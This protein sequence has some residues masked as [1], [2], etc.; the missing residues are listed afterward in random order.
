MAKNWTGLAP[1]AL[2]IGAGVWA[3][4][5]P[6]LVRS[7]LEDALEFASET[8]EPLADRFERDVLPRARKTLRET[9][10]A[11]APLLETAADYASDWLE[12]G[13][14]AAGRAI[15]W[16]EEAVQDFAERTPKVVKKT[17]DWLGREI[18]KRDIPQK[19]SDFM[20][21]KWAKELAVRLDRQEKALHG[22]N[23][24]LEHVSRP[25]GGGISLGW[26]LLGAGAF[27][28]YRNPDVAHKALDAIKDYIPGSTSDHLERAG[29][30]VKD[31][32]D[33]VARGANPMDAAK[34]AASEAGSEIGKAAKGVKA[35]AEDA[36]HDAKRG[37][38]KMGEQI[39]DA[40][41]DVA[42]TAKDTAK[43]VARDAPKAN[44]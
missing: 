23:R 26:L 33:R 16:G 35:Q 20:D 18:V 36:V 38:Q 31:G 13:Q 28:L 43:D 15:D 39:G 44:A 41:K 21:T 8:V 6:E 11:A 10:K 3:A 1:L 17:R 2:L 27:Y 40:A 22:M 9:S 42:A 12:R 32:V 24:K 19:V 37:A 4:R 34:D 30:A 5:R 14:D 7:H 29:D 25:R